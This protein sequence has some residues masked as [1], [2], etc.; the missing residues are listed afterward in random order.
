MINVL[1]AYL[2]ITHERIEDNYLCYE[3]EKTHS[4]PTLLTAFVLCLQD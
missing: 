2:F 3:K 1:R 4:L